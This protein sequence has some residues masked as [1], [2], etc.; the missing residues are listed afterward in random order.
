MSGASHRTIPLRPGPRGFRLHAADVDAAFSP[1]T[2][3]V[4]VNTPH[5]PTGTVLT[6]AELELLGRA[7]VAHDAVV[8]S[9][10]LPAPAGSLR[11]PAL[12][13]DLR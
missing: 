8:E 10:V 7:A 12:Q 5:N 1:R 13:P 3:L 2:R 9:R 4:L 11:L 6:R